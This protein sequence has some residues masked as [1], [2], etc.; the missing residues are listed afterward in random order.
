MKR[1]LEVNGVVFEIDDERVKVHGYDS[2]E[3]AKAVKDLVIMLAKECDDKDEEI[4]DLE[5]RLS[6]LSDGDG[7]FNF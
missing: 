6:Q 3:L 1:K 7:N 2:E 4:A 5:S